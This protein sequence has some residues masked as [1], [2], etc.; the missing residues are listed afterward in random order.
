MKRAFDTVFAFVH[1]ALLVGALLYAV[2]AIAAGHVLRGILL[3]AL[4]IIYYLLVLHANVRQEIARRRR[5][6]H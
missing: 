2:Y 4:L 5:R 3:L 6:R 1:L